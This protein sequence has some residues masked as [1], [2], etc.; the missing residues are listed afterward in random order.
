[1]ES[2]FAKVNGNG[3]GIEQ[4]SMNNDAETGRECS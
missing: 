3:I 4:K 2:P 1:M